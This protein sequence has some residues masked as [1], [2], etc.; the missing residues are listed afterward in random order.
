MERSSKLDDIEA[1]IEYLKSCRGGH[2]FDIEGEYQRFCPCGWGMYS[3]AIHFGYFVDHAGL[4][5]DI[6]QM[7]EYSEV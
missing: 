1:R 4:E 5:D 2:D 7:C 3:W 6:L